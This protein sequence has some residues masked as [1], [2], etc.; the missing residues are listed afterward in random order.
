MKLTIDSPIIQKGIKIT[1]LLMLNLFWIIGCIPIVTI[2]ASTIAAFS[3]TLKIVEDR[4]ETGITRQFWSAYVKNL[5]H[6]IP[7][8]LLLA[9]ILY[10]CWIYWQLFC[11]LEDGLGFLVMGLVLV[12]I[13]VFHGLYI[14]PIEAR[15]ENGLLKNL[16]NAR[17][18]LSRF[19]LKSLGLLCVLVVQVLLFTQVSYLLLY[20]GIFC[21]PILMIYTTSKTVMPIFRQLERDSKADDGFAVGASVYD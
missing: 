11:N 7:L 10:V 21:L 3:V 20:I 17:R 4:E 15:Y 19:F 6:G 1:N 13:A 2:G 8:T 12:L 16:N 9:A 5:K 14:C 18:I